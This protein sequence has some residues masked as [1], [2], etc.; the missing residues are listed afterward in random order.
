MKHEL[1][2]DLVGNAPVWTPHD[3]VVFSFTIF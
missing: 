1:K 3:S 2:S